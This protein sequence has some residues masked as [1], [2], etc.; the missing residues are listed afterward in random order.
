MYT[1]NITSSRCSICYALLST[2]TN[3]TNSSTGYTSS[4]SSSSSNRRHGYRCSISSIER[5]ILSS[6]KFQ[7]LWQKNENGIIHN[8]SI[9]CRCCDTISQIEQ[10]KNH[11][12]QLHN[13]QKILINKIEHHLTKRAL[14]LQGQQKQRINDFNPFSLNHRVFV[15]I[16]L[17]FF[18]NF[19]ALGGSCW[20]RWWYWRRW[21]KTSNNH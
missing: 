2:N 8:R 7:K 14:I 18:W 9:C 10:I 3:R 5:L 20:W 1:F 17:I 6:R 16:T 11:I 21:R 15:S 4:S 19:F 12:E 13:D